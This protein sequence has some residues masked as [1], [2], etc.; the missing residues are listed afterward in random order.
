LQCACTREAR[1]KC[2]RQL[3][4][5]FCFSLATGAAL[6]AVMFARLRGESIDATAKLPFGAFLCPAL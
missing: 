4:I 5:P 2:C 1:T 6:V 3:E